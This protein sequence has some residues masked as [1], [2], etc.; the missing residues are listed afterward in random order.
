M[1][2]IPAKVI[3]ENKDIVAF[4]IHHNFNNSLSSST[5]PTALKYADVKPVFKNDDKTNKENYRPISIL[6]TLS[7]VYERLIYNQMYPY[8]DK[9]FSKFHCGFRKGFNAQHCLIT[10][11]ER[12]RRS[13]DGSGQAGSPLT[14]LSKAFDCIHH[15]LLIA[16]LYAYG[17]DKNSLYFINSYLKVQKQRTKINSSNSAFAE[18]LFGVPQGSILESLLFNIYICDLL[19]NS[20]IDIANY[21]D[22]NTP[23]ACSSD[24][25]SVI[26]KLQKNTERIFRWFYNSN[27]ISNAEKSHLIVS[28]KKNLKIQVSSCSI[29]NEDSGKLLGIH[30]NNVLN[31]YYH[32]NQL[33]KKASK[34]LHALARI[35]KCM[36]INKR[37]M[38]MKALYLLYFPTAL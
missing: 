25:D 30:L 34:K 31:F 13:V 28:T 4:F 24:L 36:D 37:R 9:L 19:E 7:K 8:F 21:A 1:N 35:A 15:E 38:L 12:W 23:Y 33:C 18:I 10:M 26:F 6:P 14:D 16:K 27:L 32:V 5:F 29:R 11:T 2:D 3:K 17:F 22:D 20:D